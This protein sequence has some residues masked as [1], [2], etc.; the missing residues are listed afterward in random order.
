MSKIIFLKA[1]DYAVNFDISK[2][3]LATYILK[4]FE[5]I[6]IKSFQLYGIEYQDAFP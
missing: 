4:I 3:K 5:I 2:L 6:P 1:A